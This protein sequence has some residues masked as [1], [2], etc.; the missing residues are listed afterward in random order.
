MRLRSLGLRGRQSKTGE[1][2]S[3]DIAGCGRWRV[4]AM[5]GVTE[6]LTED[7][8]EGLMG[9]INSENKGGCHTRVTA[10]SIVYDGAAVSVPPA[11]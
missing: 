11:G 3:W 8:E 2:G 4:I 5:K 1:G 10:H 9:Q 7:K 6:R